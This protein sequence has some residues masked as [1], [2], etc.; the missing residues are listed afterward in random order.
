MSVRDVEMG[1]GTW[2][3]CGRKWCD[4]N[5]ESLERMEEGGSAAVV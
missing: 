1:M 5:K 4:K 2:L 3:R